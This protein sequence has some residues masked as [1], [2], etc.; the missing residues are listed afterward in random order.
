M[1]DNNGVTPD[2][3]Y[4]KQQAM[5]QLKSR[6]IK[7]TA[8]GA[9][10]AVGSAATDIALAG[11]AEAASVVATAAAESVIVPIVLTTAAIAGAGVLLYVGAE[12]LQK[13][14]HTV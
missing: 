14:W 13:W 12:R 1:T 9:G 6:V 5:N 10:I 4:A 11:A 7:G 8:A 3:A 2:A